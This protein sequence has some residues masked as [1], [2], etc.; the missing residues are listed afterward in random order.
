M[1]E[2]RI[3]RNIIRV[4]LSNDYY[5]AFLTI[6][7]DDGAPTVK[8]ADVQSVLAD[9]QV[10]FGVDIAA[11]RQAIS[12][13]EVVNRL[14]ASGIPHRNGQ[15]A[16]II[17]NFDTNMD[18]K[19]EILEDGTVNFKNMGFIKS[20][21]AGAVLVEKKLATNGISGTTVTGRN[22]SGR[23]GKDKVLAAGKNTHLSEDG[24]QLISDIDGR[25]SFDGKKVS[26][27]SV[28]E[29][30]GDVGISTGNIK[31]VGSVVVGG[32]ICDGYEIE[33]TGD[34][35]VNGVIEGAK[36]KVGGNLNLSRGIKGHGEA[37]ISVA[38]NLVTNFINSA[39]ELWVGGN[40]E[41]NAII[42]SKVKC[43]G[44]IKLTG[45]KGQ[46]LGGE[47]LCKGNLE[48]MTIGSDLEVI[49]EIKMGLDTDIVE[50]IKSI[51]SE[52]K[53]L[54]VTYDKLGK[55]IQ[56]LLNKLKLSPDNEKLKQTIVANKKEYDAVEVKT[57]EQKSR[58]RLLQELASSATTSCVRAG[59]MYPGTRVKIGNSVYHAK[60][61]MQNTILKRD[62]GDIVA[63]GY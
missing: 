59:L 43:D 24:T 63:I 62:K 53:E 27:L 37:E 21:E 44:D 3:R 51:S 20:C 16:E 60:F 17:Y 26:V 38:G 34:L 52:L 55:D 8:E 41:A 6:I 15:D 40:I 2:E 35:T 39:A 25:I 61:Q 47:T 56:T 7:R 4:E 33:T 58:L 22:I 46:L 57:Q 49:T 32:N 11:I 30:K 36:V 10:V 28:M 48:A 14:I 9:R 5:S 1:S 42:T 50:E 13:G 23:D 18:V 45:K 12:E 29:I 19:P 54:V 31:F